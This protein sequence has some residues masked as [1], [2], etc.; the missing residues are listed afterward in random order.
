MDIRENLQGE[1]YVK[2]LQEQ[3]VQSEEDIH[4]AIAA[5]ES[6]LLSTIH[7]SLFTIHYSL[8]TIHYSLLL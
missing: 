1:I 3:V 2:N 7:Y 8:F 4:A 5:G 6:E